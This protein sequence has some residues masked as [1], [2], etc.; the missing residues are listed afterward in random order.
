MCKIYVD[1]NSRRIFSKPYQKFFD[2]PVCKP[3]II[4]KETAKSFVDNLMKI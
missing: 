1:L 3:L 2:E 4:I